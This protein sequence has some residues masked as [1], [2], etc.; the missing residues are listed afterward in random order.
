MLPIRAWIF[1]DELAREQSVANSARGGGIF[2]AEIC[3]QNTQK[4]ISR[5]PVQRRTD[6]DCFNE[7]T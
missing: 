6:D 4:P 5:S 1:G 7:M 3:Q 2:L